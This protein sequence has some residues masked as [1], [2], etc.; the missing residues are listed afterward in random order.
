[1]LTTKESILAWFETYVYRQ[2]N[3]I[4]I[5]DDLIVDVIGNVDISQSSFKIKY[6]PFKFGKVS[7]QFICNIHMETLAGC[8]THVRNL[9]ISNMLNL[10]SLKHI[11]KHIGLDLYITG[12]K[13]LNNIDYLPVYIQRDLYIK[14]CGKSI[15]FNECDVR[16]MGYV[17]VLAAD[18][19]DCKYMPLGVETTVE[20]EH[21]SWDI[22]DDKVK[23][24]TDFI[25]KFEYTKGNI[26]YQ[27]YLDLF[28]E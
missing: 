15:T 11:S 5:S 1:M 3:D 13:K 27:E 21:E 8:P 28:G 9:T 4:H 10:G 12:N 25:T 26:Q 19:V 23:I 16:I 7:G 17:S 22:T 6:I 20:V 2:P 14:D 18:Y 24:Y